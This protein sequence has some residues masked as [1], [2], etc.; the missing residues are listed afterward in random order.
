MRGVGDVALDERCAR[1]VRPRCR[2]RVAVA[3]V[4][5]DPPAARDELAC[6]CEAESARGSGDDCDG[7]AAKVGAAGPNRHRELGLGLRT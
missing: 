6:E 2:E 5:D 7:H 4:D 3:R 1:L